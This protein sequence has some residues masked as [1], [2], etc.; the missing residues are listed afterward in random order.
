MTDNPGEV[1]KDMA[2]VTGGAKRLGKAIVLGLAKRGYA[3][4]LHYHNSSKEAYE[5]ADELDMLGVPVL[6]LSADLKNPSEIK[7]IFKKIDTAGYPLKL[8][9]NSA[10]LMDRKPLAKTSIKDWDSL[11]ALNVRAVWQLSMLAAERMGEGGV[12][13]NISDVGAQ[14]AWGGFGAYSITKAAVNS[15][16]MVLAQSLAPKIRVNAVA[17][18]LVLPAENLPAEGWN[19][20]VQKTPLNRSVSISAITN[21]IDFLL[22]NT[23]V[24]GE[25]I[26]VDGGRQLV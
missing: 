17:P 13:I 14:R 4:G 3:I 8:L 15:L 18:G 19:R 6:M 11:F 21:T 5:L 24:T 20:L 10:A 12:I 7:R 25:I 26:A 9:V 1:L 2:L 16:T 23:Y 22:D